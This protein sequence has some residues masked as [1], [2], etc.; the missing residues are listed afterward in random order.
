MKRSDSILDILGMVNDFIKNNKSDEQ[1]ANEFITLYKKGIS[2]DK[3]AKQYDYSLEKVKAVISQYGLT[4]GNKTLTD[5]SG[6]KKVDS[7]NSNIPE[8]KISIDIVIDV[9]NDG[10]DLDEVSK[11]YNITGRR[12]KELIL[13]AGYR[14][15]SF[16]N[17]WTKMDQEEVIDYLVQELNQGYSLYDLSAKYIKTNKD[18]L[19]FVSRMESYLKKYKYNYNVK[20]KIW[21]KDTSPIIDITKIVNELNKGQLLKEVAKS[22]NISDTN[23]RRDLS[24]NGYR[25]DRIFNVWT[26]E[27]R[28]E[29]VKKLDHDL[30]SGKVTKESL[31]RQGLNTNLLQVELRFGGFDENLVRHVQKNNPP[32]KQQTKTTEEVTSKK[33]TKSAKVKTNIVSRTVEESITQSE[34]NK[35]QTSPTKELSSKEVEILKEI[36]QDWKL[37]KIET[38]GIDN[39][40]SELNIFIDQELLMQLTKASEISG[41]SK[42]LVIAKA[43][44]EY[45]KI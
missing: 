38:S 17:F 31:K 33:G 37:K 9:L 15:Y 19:S 18:R 4:K 35:T 7:K 14:Y 39:N 2:I 40:P 30:T 44:K 11:Q 21:T 6:S 10:V 25:Y 20:K 13:L 23:I 22:V 45:L 5:Y 34:K 27:K 3:I 41:I 36:L 26:Q 32:S 28:S 29:L 8:L 1:L 43:L 24:N 16:M 12:L 42:S